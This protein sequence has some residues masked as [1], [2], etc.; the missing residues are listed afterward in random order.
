MVPDD[1]CN[2]LETVVEPRF[3]VIS[4]IKEALMGY[5]AQGSLMTGSGSCVFGVFAGI[6]GARK[7]AAHVSQSTQWRSYLVHMIV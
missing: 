1:L 6:A 3:P 7:A 4:S 2:D 5:G